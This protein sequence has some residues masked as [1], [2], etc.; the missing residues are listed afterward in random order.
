MPRPDGSQGPGPL[1]FLAID[2]LVKLIVC[3]VSA[4]GG[5]EAFL[6]RSLAVTTCLLRRDAEDKAGSFNARPYL[7]LLLGLASELVVGEHCG[8]DRVGCLGV[9]CVAQGPHDGGAHDGGVLGHCR[10]SLAVGLDAAD[11]VAYC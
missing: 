5:G 4:H 11:C 9:A 10:R 7:R 1:S 3:L 2:P 8:A 6:Q